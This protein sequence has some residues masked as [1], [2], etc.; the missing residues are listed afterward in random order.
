MTFSKLRSITYLI[1]TDGATFTVPANCVSI[2]WDNSESGTPA[3][4]ADRTGR[5]PRKVYDSG[6]T[7]GVIFPRQAS[8]GYLLEEQTFDITFDN[9]GSTLALKV[10]VFVR[11]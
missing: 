5:L 6:A 3:N 8:Y 4:V 2:E 10:T 7:S 1:D 11:V 9:P